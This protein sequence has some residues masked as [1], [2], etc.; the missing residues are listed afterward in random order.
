M[1]RFVRPIM[2]RHGIGSSIA[3]VSGGYKDVLTPVGFTVPFTGTTIVSGGGGALQAAITGAA[4]S[5]RLLIT[6]SA[7]Y[8][9]VTVTGAT[10]LT[11]EADAGQTPS[12]TAA[13]GAGNHCVVIGAGN[14]GLALLGLSLIGNGNAG[15]GNQTNDGLVNMNNTIAT[16]DRLILDKCVFSELVPASGAPGLQMVGT[17]GTVH[18]K[19][20]VHRCT[21]KN[22]SASATAQLAGYGA[23]TVG[24]FDNVFVQNTLV[25]RQTAAIA[26]AASNMRGLVM[27][28]LSTLAEDVLCEDLGTAGSNEPFKHNGE[29]IFGTAVGIS[30]WNNCVAYNCHRGYRINL[31]LANMSVNHSVWYNN[32]A[33]IAAGQ[34]IMEQSAGSEAV[35]DSIAQS[36]GDATAFSATVIEDHNDV[37]N[38]AAPGKVLDATDKTLDFM[39]FDAANR[40]FFTTNTVLKTAGSF[41]RAMGVRYASGEKIFWAGTPLGT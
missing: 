10:N 13:A 34:T 36:A 14:S 32:M 5:T 4:A 26:R 25:L 22:N 19:V 33:G 24:G 29:A 7:A 40:V 31:A 38:V 1:A 28:N 35:E 15:S 20:W 21:F 16:F 12:I 27:K 18:T 17:D 30:K 37:F 9:P 23:C 8:T 3:I 41:G 2:P 6:D 39:P 11:I